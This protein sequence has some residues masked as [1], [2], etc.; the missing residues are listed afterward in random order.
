VA[1][2]SSGG[3]SSC[4]GKMSV[5]AP[6]NPALLIKPALAE[7]RVPEHRPFLTPEA[8]TGGSSTPT[9]PR[10][11]TDPPVHRTVPVCCSPAP[12]VQSALALSHL[13]VGSPLSLVDGLQTDS[14]ET[15]TAHR[16]REGRRREEG[17]SG[18]RK[19]TRW[20]RCCPRRALVLFAPLCPARS[21]A[22]CFACCCRCFAAQ[23][24]SVPSLRTLACA[25]IANCACGRIGCCTCS[26]AGIGLIGR[27]SSRCCRS[28]LHRR[29]RHVCLL[30]VSD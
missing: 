3:A 22:V 15:G 14:C 27:R 6:C 12:L 29:C 25:E 2:E 13:S 4:R 8:L 9:R 16:G 10:R 24:S 20:T 18:H 7:N 11:R 1:R 21:A 5:D 30:R 23:P 17:E 26:Y 28:S 19:R